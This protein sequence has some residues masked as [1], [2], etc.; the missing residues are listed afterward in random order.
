MRLHKRLVIL[1]A[2]FETK[3]RRVFFCLLVGVDKLFNVEVKE[4]A[5]EDTEDD[6]EEDVEEEGDEE[7]CL[8][9]DDVD[10]NEEVDSFSLK[11]T[12]P[13]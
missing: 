6:E 9:D 12:L 8:D 7:C 1:I 2:S 10:D 5:F 11:F 13:Y 4:E 3:L